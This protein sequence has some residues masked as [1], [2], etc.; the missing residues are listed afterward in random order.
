[1]GYPFPESRQLRP[2]GGCVRK[3][4]EHVGILLVPHTCNK[5]T[6]M[7]DGVQCCMSIRSEFSDCLLEELRV[8]YL[9]GPLDKSAHNCTLS[10]SHHVS[11]HLTLSMKTRGDCR[12]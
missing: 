6:F 8:T 9:G 1:M 10:M 11:R 3:G 12:V 2:S 7:G 5:Y 4:A